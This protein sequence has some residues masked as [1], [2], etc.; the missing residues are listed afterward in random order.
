MDA[1]E[2]TSRKTDRSLLVCVK[3]ERR[4]RDREEEQEL[5]ENAFFFPLDAKRQNKV[6]KKGFPSRPPSWTWRC[7][8]LAPSRLLVTHL[9]LAWLLAGLCLSLARSD[10]VGSGH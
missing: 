8:L 3:V 9:V 2:C 7:C 1:W 10:T 6:I 5:F 4:E